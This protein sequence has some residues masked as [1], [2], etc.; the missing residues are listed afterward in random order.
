V[1]VEIAL[2]PRAESYRVFARVVGGEAREFEPV[3]SPSDPN[4]LITT[5]VG[6]TEL[7]VCASA[8][9]NGG[10]SGRAAAVRVRVRSSA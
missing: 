8:V 5:F 6:G 10:E 4:F 7:E 2:P 3:G 1:K 9:N